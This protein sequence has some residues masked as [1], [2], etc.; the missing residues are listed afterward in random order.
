MCVP[1]QSPSS[2]ESPHS[3]GRDTHVPTRKGVGTS[4]TD[5]PDPGARGPSDFCG[6]RKGE[7]EASPRLVEL[8]VSGEVM[9]RDT[10]SL[11]SLQ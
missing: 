5:R 3:L 1:H 4:T 8:S 7:G 2:E 10:E 6:V 11:S 9:D